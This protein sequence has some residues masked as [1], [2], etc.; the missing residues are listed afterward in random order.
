MLQ[1]RI[2]YFFFSFFFNSDLQNLAQKCNFKVLACWSGETWQGNNRSNEMTT[3][4]G[5]CA[6]VEPELYAPERFFEELLSEAAPV[7]AVMVSLV[8]IHFNT[9]QN[10]EIINI[11]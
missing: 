11:L 7:S 4:L 3:N 1:N 5:L 6:E 2:K 10:E 9:L 8:N